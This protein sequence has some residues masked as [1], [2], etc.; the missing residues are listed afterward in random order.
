MKKNKVFLFALLSCAVMIISCGKK[1]GIKEANEEVISEDVVSE[2]VVSVDAEWVDLGLPSGT[3]WAS[4]NLGATSESDAGDYFSWGETSPKDQ[5]TDN[6]YKAP[7]LEWYDDEL[8]PEYDAAVAYWGKKWRM[9]TYE[10]FKELLNCCDC[11][12]ETKDGVV[13]FTAVG[14]NGNYIIL[15]MGGMKKGFNPIDA[16]DDGRYYTSN[17]ELSER[18]DGYHYVFA[19]TLSRGLI[20]MKDVVAGTP[21]YGY[22]IRPVLYDEKAHIVPLTENNKEYERLVKQL[23]AAYEK[24]DIEKSWEILQSMQEVVNSFAQSEEDGKGHIYWLKTGGGKL[25]D[26]MFKD[27]L[28][29]AQIDEYGEKHQSSDGEYSYDY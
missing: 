24:K 17:R 3:K 21:T 10:Q 2:D 27:S 13:V 23:R 5:Y 19:F 25:M 7:K 18:N 15:P 26:F 28:F 16:G 22:N 4:K 14:P 6:S 8:Q 11:K 12:Y 29:T 1:D 20:R 9:P